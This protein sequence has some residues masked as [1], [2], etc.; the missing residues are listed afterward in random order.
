[1]VLSEGVEGQEMPLRV[2]VKAG[3][4]DCLV[5]VLIRG[6]EG[7]S[8]SFADDHGE[9]PLSARSRPVKLDREDYEKLWWN[10]FRSFTTKPGATLC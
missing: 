5:D 7:V 2:S 3:T 6:I 8:I 1:M 9:V 10:I 4:L